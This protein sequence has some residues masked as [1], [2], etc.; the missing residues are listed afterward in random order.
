[1]SHSNLKVSIVRGELYGLTS[2]N[3]ENFQDRQPYVGSASGMY[4]ILYIIVHS[5]IVIHANA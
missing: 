1:M 3:L 5:L 4:S 2:V